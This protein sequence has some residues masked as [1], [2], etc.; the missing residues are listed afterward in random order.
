MYYAFFDESELVCFTE[1]SGLCARCIPWTYYRYFFKKNLF[2]IVK[3]KMLAL[4]YTSLF[5][6]MYFIKKLVKNENKV[7]LATK[8]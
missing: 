1:L 2:L 3:I 4:L 8:N 7:Y 5:L 6:S